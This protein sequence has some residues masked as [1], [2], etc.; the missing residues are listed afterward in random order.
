[1][2]H[3]YHY[4]VWGW[5]IAIYLLCDSPTKLNCFGYR[6]TM[7][8]AI[9]QN[10]MLLY[11]LLINGTEVYLFEEYDT[12]NYIYIYIIRYQIYTTILLSYVCYFACTNTQ[13]F[14]MYA[15]ITIC[16]YFS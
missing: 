16:L 5:Y 10:N 7:I 13:S 6:S 11:M 8:I 2:Q 15:I 14:M 4:I 9:C 3:D 1:M 12:I